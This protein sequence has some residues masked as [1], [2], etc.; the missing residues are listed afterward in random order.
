MLPVTLPAAEVRSMLDALLAA[1]GAR[2]RVDLERQTV[3]GPN[4]DV[5]AFGV[6]AF[7][8]TCLLEGLDE[9][10]LTLGSGEAIDRYERERRKVTPWLFQDL[11]G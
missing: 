9:I 8:K 4:G 2:V 7:A 1:P 3:T 10:A 11:A 5:H 6:A